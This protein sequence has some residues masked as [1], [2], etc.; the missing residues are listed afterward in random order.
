VSSRGGAR[1]KPE[2]TLGA[3]EQKPWEFSSPFWAIRSR[4]PATVSDGQRE[5]RRG[6][7]NPGD[8]AKEPGNPT[9]ALYLGVSASPDITS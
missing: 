9:L 3:D 7:S 8:R 4:G 5:V 2:A 6:V 1:R